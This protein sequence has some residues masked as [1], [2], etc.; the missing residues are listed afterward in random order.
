MSHVLHFI[1]ALLLVMPWNC[2]AESPIFL[3]K[4]HVGNVPLTFDNAP[5]TSALGRIGV[6][7]GEGE[8]VL[9]GVEVIVEDGQEPLVTARIPAGSPLNDALTQVV[10]AVPGYTFAAVSPHLVNVFPRIADSDPEDLLN[11][12][13]PKLELV[14][15]SPSNFLS[16]PARFVPEL[17]AALSRGRQAGCEIGPGLSDKAPG[18]TISLRDLTLRQAMNRVSEASISSAQRNQG[19]AFGWVYLRETFPS[20]AHPADS[21]RVHDAW[22]GPR[23]TAQP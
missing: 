22:R 15:V 10:Q 11:L 12:Q 5:L 7:L 4:L 8:F 2:V 17:K 13:V 9:F 21:W 20:A 16:N 14:G 6:S 18:I 3:G 19:L 23:R 1:L